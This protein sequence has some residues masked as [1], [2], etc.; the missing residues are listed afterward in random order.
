MSFK[1]PKEESASCWLE[2]RESGLEWAVRVADLWVLL[3]AV[4]LIQTAGQG[5]GRVELRI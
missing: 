1:L 4:R 5:G 3:E 2:S